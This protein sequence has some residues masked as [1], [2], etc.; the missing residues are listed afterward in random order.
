M[1]KEERNRVANQMHG[2]K[3]ETGLLTKCMEIKE[4]DR[5][6]DQMHGNKGTRQGC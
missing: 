6:A 4:Q 3:N 2:K 1:R 5:V